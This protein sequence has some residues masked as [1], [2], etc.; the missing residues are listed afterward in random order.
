MKI[1]KNGKGHITKVAVTPIDGNNPFKYLLLQIQEA[2]CNE[3][4]YAAFGTPVHYNLQI[5]TLG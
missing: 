4:W 2:V 1:Y 3:T 5:L